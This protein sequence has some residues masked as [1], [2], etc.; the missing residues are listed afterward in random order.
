MEIIKTFTKNNISI[1]IFG[2]Y[3]NPLFKAQQIG[4][5]LDLKNIRENLSH[6]NPKWKV[7]KKTDTP[8]G[9]QLM[10]FLTEPGL[11]KLIMRSNKTEAVEFQNWVLEDVIPSIRQ[12][13]AYSM[14]HK[15]SKNLTFNIQSE[16][17]LH[18]KVVQFIK[19]RFPNSLFTTTLG[20]LQ[21][22]SEKRLKAWRM[23]YL[24]GSPDIIIMNLN[25]KYSGFCIEFKSPT[26]KGSPSNKQLKLLKAY[27]HN[28]FKI[29]LSNDYDVI[30]EQLL[31]YFKD[32]RIKCQYCNRLFKSD[33]SIVK[34]HK[35]F[36]KIT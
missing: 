2:T 9:S 30:V 5:M 36:H 16:M 12:N 13:G 26:G 18:S 29:L 20:E 3:E 1:D 27:K 10:T 7:V 19:K 31:E 17:D 34:H 24:A 22:S 25:K 15:Y 23:G 14:N 4:Q 8:G 28:G 11:Y 35:Y 6:M 21:S 33:S 32:V